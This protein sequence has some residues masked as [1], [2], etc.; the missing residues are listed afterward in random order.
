MRYLILS[1]IHANLEGL[2]AVLRESEG[3]WD[4]VVCLGDTV[5]YGADPNAC[6][7]FVRENVPH[8]VRGNHDK[9]CAG[10]DDLEWFNA[11]ARASALWTQDVLAPEN[12]EWLRGLPKGP[13]HL[14]GFQILHG[15]P[16]DEDEYLL[17]AGDA[18]QLTGYLDTPL[19]FFGH[20]HVQGGFMLH[21]NGVQRIPAV[22]RKSA[23]A[24]FAIDPDSYVLINPG[25]AGQPRDGDPRAAFAIYDDEQRLVRYHRVA[26]DIA[27]AQA[28]IRAAS[29]PD[30]LARRLSIGQ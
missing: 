16:L 21:R 27:A 11:A 18:Q 24:D 1:D 6:A 13:L 14:D 26:Y 9:A 19:S 20:T 7:A 28:K 2:Q 5:G 29:L 10:L 30:V 17:Q 15:S 25:S 23:H 3:A 22:P 12:M 4:R 8:V